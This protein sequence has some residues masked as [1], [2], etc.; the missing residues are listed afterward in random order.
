MNTKAVAIDGPSG[1][2][3][4]TI[5]RAVAKKLGY[6]Y[7]DTGAL[8]RAIGYYILS[9]GA[10]TKDAQAVE[11]LLSGMLVEMRF[12]NGEQHV[13]INEQDVTHRLR[14]NEVAMAASH[15]SAMKSVRAFLFD[16]QK[17]I[18]RENNVVMDGRDIGTVVL[19]DAQV[20]VFLTASA[21]ERAQRRFEELM[22]KGQRV[23]Y[24]TVLEGIMERDDNDVHRAISPLVQAP[25]AILVDTTGNSLDKSVQTLY[26][27]ISRRLD[28]NS[29]AASAI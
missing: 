12:V 25:D 16:L 6:F 20:K 24:K 2:G 17:N 13:F 3:K 27:L 29:S 1:A 18:A 8:Y 23:N 7:V 9:K 19:P 15:V 10:D 26:D 5:A 4:S 28:I 11:V 22:Q 14:D 21:E